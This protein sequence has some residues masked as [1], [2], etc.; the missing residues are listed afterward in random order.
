MLYFLSDGSR[1]RKAAGFLINPKAVAEKEA[2]FRKDLLEKDTWFADFIIGENHL[3]D[4]NRKE[5]IEAYRCSY[6]AIQRSRQS[7][8]L[9]VDKLYAEQ[10]RQRLDEL[11]GVDKPS[12]E[13]GEPVTKR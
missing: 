5:A 1:E 11:G 6:E 8:N 4:G 13:G 2:G 10:V 9:G 7:D 3:N 12:A